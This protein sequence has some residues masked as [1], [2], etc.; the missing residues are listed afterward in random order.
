MSNFVLQKKSVKFIIYNIL[1]SKIISFTADNII[2]DFIRYMKQN[3]KQKSF[4]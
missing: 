2:V 4:V 1:Y 3:N